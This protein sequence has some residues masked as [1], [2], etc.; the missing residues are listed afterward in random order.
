MSNSNG[1]K[2][3]VVVRVSQGD[4]WT[5]LGNTLLRALQPLIQANVISIGLTTPPGSPLNGDTYIVGPGATGA[6]AGKDNSM[7]YWSTDNPLTPS[8]EWE[9]FAPRAG[10]IV[11]NQTDNGSYLFN[12]SAWVT[13]AGSGLTGTGTAKTLPIWTGT[14][15]LANSL[16]SDSGSGNYTTPGSYDA[17]SFTASSIGAETSA[18]TATPTGTGVTSYTYCVAAQ[19]GNG[20]L[21]AQ[22]SPSSPVTN[23]ATLD[24]SHF[25][26]IAWTLMPGVGAYNVYR[27]TGGATQG[28]IG[29][30][31]VN[32]PPFVDNGLVGDGNPAPSTDESGSIIAQNELSLV[33][34]QQ[35]AI[36]CGVDQVLK[37]GKTDPGQQPVPGDF[38]GSMKFTNMHF[39][40]G[41][42]QSTGVNY[43][44]FVGGV[45]VPVNN[46][47][48]PSCYGVNLSA[49][50]HDLYTVPSGK[51]ALVID[52]TSTVPAG[53]PTSVTGLSEA[54]ISGTYH[55]F[56]FFA[57]GQ[58]AGHYGE[59]RSLA[60][61]LLRAGE[62]FAVN[63]D[64]S[65][66][67]AWPFIVEFDSV[68]NITD[69]RLL[70]LSSGNNTLFT[71]PG[72]KTVAFVG[73]PSGLD[74]P[75]AGRV[76]YYNGTLADRTIQAN[77]VPASGS[78]SL[79]NAI[80]N[81]AVPSGQMVQAVLYGG[82]APG[83]TINI[84][85]DSSASGQIAWIVYTTP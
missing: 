71:M 25:N 39:A 21:T 15:S 26:T 1:P 5:S 83:D 44:L 48:F 78:P 37:I 41:S 57:L 68:A 76:W 38:R 7:A 32:D 45:Q 31:G 56:D 51:M 75:G 22:S 19:D 23:A 63:T 9:F 59:Q 3:P 79:N 6:W 27:L 16:V 20:L 65:G 52:V 53:N 82:L 35:A 34:F 54:K 49:G 62:I 85:T 29:A 43:T 28:L 72:G 8:G 40:D 55:P 14:G 10:W 24:G 73:M 46:V 47:K 58:A 36:S 13:T 30:W 4:A 12:G 70:S 61:F 81:G 66:L 80:F 60:P 33:G 18:V 74:L 11:G 64:H 17:Q 67:T 84:N 77:L 50:N 69:T 42:T 2:L